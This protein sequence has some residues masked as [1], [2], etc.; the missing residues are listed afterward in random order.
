MYAIRSYY[1]GWC[2]E[3]FAAL[4]SAVSWLFVGDPQPLLIL[5]HFWDTDLSAVIT[6]YSIHYTKLY[7]QG[8][9]EAACDN[10]RRLQSG[11]TILYR[12]A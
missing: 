6:S 1:D 7:E 8:I 12:H 4:D 3:G 2:E 5:S 10:L 9:F 11:E